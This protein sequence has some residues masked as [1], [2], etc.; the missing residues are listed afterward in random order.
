MFHYITYLYNSI[1]RCFY[2]TPEL[3]NYILPFNIQNIDKNSEFQEFKDNDIE[4]NKVIFTL[5]NLPDK[6][7][8]LLFSDNEEVCNEYFY[9]TVKVKDRIQNQ[10]HKEIDEIFHNLDNINNHLFNDKIRY[11][12]IRVNV[13][14]AYHKVMDH[15]NCIIIDKNK[16]YILFFEPKF[17]FI[18]DAAD[19]TK[20]VS[21]KIDIGNYSII[22]PQDIGYDYY[23]RLQSYD[24]FCQS[25]VIFVFG[26]IVCNDIGN[27]TNYRS[28]INSIITHENLGCMLYHIHTLLKQSGYDICEQKIIW[29]FP[30][31][32]TR[33]MLNILHLYFSN[34]NKK[35]NET[36]EQ[37]EQL[38]DL[39]IEL[40]DDFVIVSVNQ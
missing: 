16:K 35:H 39:G 15:V 11:I 10:T 29:S 30:T 38:P 32:K 23:T 36:I 8:N 26:I 24:I 37:I 2:I 5:N 18:Y 33:N 14:D 31:K 17:E 7:H 40:D 19:L 34:Y 25:Y 9:I 27:I 4:I 13:I 28:I 3:N 12:F 1:K 20:F 21:E 22:M 6:V